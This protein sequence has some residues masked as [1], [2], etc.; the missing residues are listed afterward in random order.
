ME[1]LVTYGWAV[2]IL[3]ILLVSLYELG[4]FNPGVSGVRVQPGACQ[5]FRPQGAWTKFN[6][7]LEGECNS[8]LPQYVM[9]LTGA[10]SYVYIQNQFQP[11]QG[12]KATI[13]IWAKWSGAPPGGRQEI[14]GSDSSLGNEVNPIIAVNDSGVEDAESWVC[15]STC[16]PEAWSGAGTITPGKWYFFVSR[17]NGSDVSLWISGSQ[18]NNA[19]A[20]GNLQAQ[21]TGTTTYIGSR[22]NTCCYFNGEVANAQLYNTSLS[23]SQIQALY[24]EG[25]GGAPITLQNLVG[26]WP[27]NGNSNDYSGNRLNG[28]D[29]EVSYISAWTGGYTAP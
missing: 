8:G 22:S 5:V 9:K 1:Y 20:S 12:T 29:T 26:W 3:A 14:L 24:N 13:V 10:S 27:L 2:L 11:L 18:V 17:Y 16:W 4:V 7:A 23:Q 19:G 25:I 6:V 15:V 21:G 28:V